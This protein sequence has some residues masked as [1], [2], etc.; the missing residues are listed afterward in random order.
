MHIQLF[1]A[2]HINAYEDGRDLVVDLCQGDPSG[3][4]HYMELKT[5]REAEQGLG[6]ATSKLRRF[7]I[8]LDTRMTAMT[9]PQVRFYDENIGAL[10][11]SI[12]DHYESPLAKLVKANVMKNKAVYTTAPVAGG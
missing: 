8:N 10:E 5:M 12:L 9:T 7:T 4:G 2:H 11:E 1:S 3:L 6:K